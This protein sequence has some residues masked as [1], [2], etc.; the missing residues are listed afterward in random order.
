MRIGID[1]RLYGTASGTGI[2]R[3]TEELL[4]ALAAVDTANT[5]VVFLQRDGFVAFT[6]PN[7]RW[8]KI[9][10]DFRPYT[11]AVQTRFPRLLRQQH[12]DLMHFT[13]F[14]HPVRCPV[15]FITTVHD[16]ILLRYP[17]IR[18]STLGSL[19]FWMKYLAY[20]TVLRHVARHSIRICT[21]SQTVADDV[22]GMLRVSKERIAVTPLGVDHG[23]IE[24]GELR[25]DNSESNIIHSPFAIRN[26]FLYIGNAYP[27]KNLEQLVRVWPTVIEAHPDLQLIIVG[28]ADDFTERLQTLVGDRTPIVFMGVVDDAT[29]RSLL[30]SAHAYISPSRCEGFDLPTVEA[31]AAGTP[32]IASDIPVHREILNN[33]ALFFPVDDDRACT[34][35]IHRILIDNA[36]RATLEQRGRTVAA[37]YHWHSCAIRTFNAY[38]EAIASRGTAP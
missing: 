17:S 30:V 15:P 5:Y 24:N 37:E 14:D 4:R 2:G 26:F 25:I 32:V 9:L 19:R 36:L 11:L 22:H 38:R 3:Y 27:H 13:H 20:R 18:A 34:E 1:A 33:G 23:G 29:R 35:A 31:L 28:R 6:P 7:A 12:L 16:L 8:S 10:A 21:P